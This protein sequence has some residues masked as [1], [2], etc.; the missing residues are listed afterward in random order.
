MKITRRIAI[1]AFPVILLSGILAGCSQVKT[2]A[3][4][5]VPVVTSQTT[6]VPTITVSDANTSI[7]KN[8]GNANFVLLDV[9]TADEFNSGHL[10]GAINLDYYAADFKANIAKLDKNK[11]YLVYCRTGIRGAASVQIMLNLGFTKTQNMAGGITEWT[12]EGYA[13]VK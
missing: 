3:S 4:S 8:S 1:V 13:V 11:Q 6:D 10:A 5:T 12:Q 2:T 7:Q 9:R